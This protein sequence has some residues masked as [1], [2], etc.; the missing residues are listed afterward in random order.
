[1]KAKEYKQILDSHAE[2]DEGIIQIGLKF[3]EETDKLIT[4]RNAQSNEAMIAIYKEMDNKWK[5][6]CKLDN[7]LK[8]EGYWVLIEG[9]MPEV[10][11]YLKSLGVVKES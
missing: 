6:F 1:M 9:M 10:Y 8:P 11:R 3:L 5:A 2:L 4:S 7:R